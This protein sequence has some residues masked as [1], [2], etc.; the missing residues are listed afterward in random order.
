M[1]FR[2]VEELVPESTWTYQKAVL[3]NTFCTLFL[4]PVFSRSLDSYNGFC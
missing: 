2:N 1:P 4:A 3:F